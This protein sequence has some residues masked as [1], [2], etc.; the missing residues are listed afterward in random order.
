MNLLHC[1]TSVGSVTDQT[2]SQHQLLQVEKP[3]RPTK[4]HSPVTRGYPIPFP[5][6]R[7]PQSRSLPAV[8]TP[9]ATGSA[10]PTCFSPQAPKTR[11]S[12]AHFPGDSIANRLTLPARYSLGRRK[13]SIP[14]TQRMCNYNT[15]WIHTSLAHN[16]Q[17]TRYIAALPSNCSL[18]WPSGNS[19]QPRRE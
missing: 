9:R 11:T 13:R 12:L 14:Q 10:P 17:S 2:V 4:A 6:C 15:I 18:L 8:L 16:N 1:N 5:W 3:P 19:F 7:P